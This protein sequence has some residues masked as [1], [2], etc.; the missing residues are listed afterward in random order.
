MMVKRIVNLNLKIEF[1]T[2][3]PWQE[4]ELLAYR[5][6]LINQPLALN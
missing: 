4:N 1:I 5:G 6:Y 2:I 3:N